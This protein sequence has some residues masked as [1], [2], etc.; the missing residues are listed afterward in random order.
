MPHDLKGRYIRP[1]DVVKAQPSNLQPQ[2][3]VVGVV[4]SIVESQTCSGKIRYLGFGQV[5][6]DY[7]NAGESELILKADGSEPEAT[8]GEAIGLAR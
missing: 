8:D 7:F 4:T 1:G 2:R 3:K 5:D 6:E